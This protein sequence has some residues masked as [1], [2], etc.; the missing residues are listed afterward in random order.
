VNLEVRQQNID[1]MRTLRAGM[2]L[3]GVLFVAMAYLDIFRWHRWYLAPEMVIMALIMA[4]TVILATR[5]IRR[6]RAKLLRAE[7]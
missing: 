2:I 6:W 3:M 1:I 5:F 7:P 4:A